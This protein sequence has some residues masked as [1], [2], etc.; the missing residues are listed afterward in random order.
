MPTG[1]NNSDGDDLITVKS[2]NPVVEK[3]SLWGSMSSHTLLCHQTTYRSVGYGSETYPFCIFHFI[4]CSWWYFKDHE[5]QK[6]SFGIFIFYLP[7]SHFCVDS[8]RASLCMQSY[9]YNVKICTVITMAP[10]IILSL[11]LPLSLSLSLSLSLCVCVC[12]CHSKVPITSSDYWSKGLDNILH[13]F[14]SPS[15]HAFTLSLGLM[16]FVNTHCIWH[17]SVTQI[18]T[19]S[20]F[21]EATYTHGELVLG[22]NKPCICLQV[23]P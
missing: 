11:S 7:P 2:A 12:V 17:S 4:W 5:E 3:D 1:Q 8:S 13:C 9:F 16:N 15:P 19:I 6:V 10:P 21:Q 23:L 20:F 22:T 14:L 18:L